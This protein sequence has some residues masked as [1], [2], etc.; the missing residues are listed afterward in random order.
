MLV[1]AEVLKDDCTCSKLWQFR[2]MDAIET[3]LAVFSVGADLRLIQPENIEAIVV[4]LVVSSAGAV[5]KAWQFAYIEAVDA[6][7]FVA[8][9][10]IT[11]CKALQLLN[12][13]A[14]EVM[15]LKLWIFTRSKKI[16]RVALPI[17]TAVSAVVPLISTSSQGEGRFPL[18]GCAANEMV[19]K[20]WPL[21]GKIL[22]IACRYPWAVSVVDRQE[23]QSKTLDAI[24]F[25]A[26]SCGA[27]PSP[28]S[29]RYPPPLVAAILL[30]ARTA[31]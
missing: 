15:F 2:N 13:L 1:Q 18:L 11:S 30:R 23:F 24:V 5:C 16:E 22:I 31:T 29:T 20:F 14:S 4:T 6:I 3:V 9:G 26:Y 27:E 8:V 10:I 19:V 12:K 25:S 21:L 17:P 28:Q 7:M